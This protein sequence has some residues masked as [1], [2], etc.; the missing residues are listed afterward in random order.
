VTPK[1][2]AFVE[3]YAACGNATEA[4]SKAGYSARYAGTNA[5]KLLKNTNVQAALAA[6]TEKVASERIATAIER[7]EYWTALMRGEKDG[8]PEM[9]KLGLKASELLGRVQQDFIARSEVTGANGTPLHA[10]DIQLVVIQPSVKI[11]D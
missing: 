8:D 6:L 3:Y 10:P 1:Q 7:Q 9:L 2:Q 11:E 5:E 4:A